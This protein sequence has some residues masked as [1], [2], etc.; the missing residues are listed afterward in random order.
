MPIR[1]ITVG[2]LLPTDGGLYDGE[3]D[4][5]YEEDDQQQEEYWIA[6]WLQSLDRSVDGSEELLD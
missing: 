2:F 3:P 6:R 4:H 5:L 1:D